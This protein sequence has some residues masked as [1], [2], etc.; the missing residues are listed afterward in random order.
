M[1]LSW[2]RE[3]ASRS[4]SPRSTRRSTSSAS[5]TVRAWATVMRRRSRF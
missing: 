3:T 1:P 2:A 4:T 5:S